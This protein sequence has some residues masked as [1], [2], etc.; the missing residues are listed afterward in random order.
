MEA[1]GDAT[2]RIKRIRH[3]EQ[4]LPI[5]M[6]NENGPCPLLALSNVL[7]L[8]HKLS[9]HPDMSSVTFQDL[10]SLIG[11][12]MLELTSSADDYDDERLVN[13][14]RNLDDAMAL[15]P[16]L[17]RGLDVNVRFTSV[18]AFEFSEDLL[19]FDLLDVR[20]LHG[21]LVDPQDHATATVVGSL[22]YNQL[23]E[24]LARIL[25]D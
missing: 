24:K 9:L 23:V 25:S 8:R 13:L 14:R 11:D 17:Q 15:F 18:D 21:W 2:Y 5:L 1:V 10:V 22:T 12:Y 3:N 7:L 16:K 4:E 6:Q 19:I 20:L